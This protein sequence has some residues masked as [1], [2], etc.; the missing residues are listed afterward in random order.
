[1]IGNKIY[2]SSIVLKTKQKKVA[3]HILKA[4]L[5]RNPENKSVPENR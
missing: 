2:V 1:M 3:K 4:T 5:R